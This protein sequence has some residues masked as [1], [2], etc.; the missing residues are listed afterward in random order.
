MTTIA[1]DGKTISADGR[2]TQNEVIFTD[3]YCKF[4]KLKNGNI[5]AAYGSVGE[6][7]D[8]IEDYQSEKKTPRKNYSCVLYVVTTSREVF[9]LYINKDGEDLIFFQSPLLFT[10]ALDENYFSKD[11]GGT[12]EKFALAAMDYG[13]DSRAAVAYACSRDIYSG[14]RIL[15]FDIE[16]F[17]FV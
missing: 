11:A 10:S 15:T 2:M 7:Y 12:G 14:G 1:F 17:D 9:E 6:I 4:Y 16:K 5:A 13:C 8:F 3:S